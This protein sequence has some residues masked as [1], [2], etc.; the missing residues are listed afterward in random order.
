MSASQSGSSVPGSGVS[1]S[2]SVSDY[3]GGPQDDKGVGSGER[4]W[5]YTLG[6]VSANVAASA[7]VVV[8]NKVVLAKASYPGFAGLLLVLHQLCVLGFVRTTNKGVTSEMRNPT[9]GSRPS[10]PPSILWNLGMNFCSGLSVFTSN[11]TLL[12]CSV[13]FHQLSRLFALPIGVAFDYV[14]YRKS[15]STIECMCLAII[16]YSFVS[17]SQ[18]D[19]TVTVFGAIFAFT[20]IAMSQLNAVVVKH[21]CKDCNITSNTMLYYTVPISLITGTMTWVICD[22]LFPPKTSGPASTSIMDPDTDSAHSGLL[23]VVHNAFFSGN[24]PTTYVFLSCVLA[25]STQLLSTLVAS[26]C[27]SLMYAVLSQAKTVATLLLGAVVFSSE[28]SSRQAF[29]SSMCLLGS[30]CYA[31]IDVTAPDKAQAAGIGDATMRF[32]A[33]QM[34]RIVFALLA[35]CACDLFIRVT[36]TNA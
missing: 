17:A 32:R 18:A 30:M 6:I 12:F 9:D 11:L 14:F 31:F 23:G 25:M 20:S 10:K 8:A 1:V 7:G 5:T 3:K 27:S 2:V 22:R 16:A 34:P 28:F 35:V 33:K 21:I 26:I 15:R 29:S 36:G 19:A 4:P 24:F 13:A